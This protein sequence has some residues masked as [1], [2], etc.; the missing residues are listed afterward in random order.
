MKHK[1]HAKKP[2]KSFTAQ[3]EILG[4][5]AVVYRTI[6]N[7][8]YWQFRTWIKAEK[9]HFRISLKTR[10]LSTAVEKSK[11]LY[12]QLQSQSQ[13]GVKIFGISWREL[14]DDY[15]KEQ[16]VRVTTKRITVGRLGTI[17]SQLK[18]LLEFLGDDTKVGEIGRGKFI[19]YA[20]WRR[21]KNVGVR[22]VTIRNEHATINNLIKVA[23][24]RGYLPYA[25]AD[26]EEIRIR[27]DEIGRRDTFTAD[28]YATLYTSARTWVSEK[29]IDEEERRLR[30]MIR[31]FI[32]IAANSFARFGELRQLKWK[33]V[34]VFS[35]T[36]SKEKTTELVN[37]TIEG[38]TSKIRKSRKIVCNG[39]EYFQRL[40]SLSQHTNDEDY[41]FSNAR[42]GMIDKKVY[43]AL[44]HDL[45]TK[46]G[47]GNSKVSYYGLRHFGI[48]M[49][50]YAGVSLTDISRLA[51]TSYQYIENHY[52]HVDSSKLVAA[53]TKR[54]R[55]D[56]NGLIIR[57]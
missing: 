19:E 54:F 2:S 30:Q 16:E 3:H 17:K 40:R 25:S 12:L 42:G 4:G 8:D 50:I 41:V 11:T 10:D 43:Y 28:E 32:L 6:Q 31:H 34:N 13:N 53:A 23:N 24:R 15:L 55:M 51:G 26:L 37:L 21:L 38:E 36:D 48:T 44:W 20:Q 35:H 27:G 47:L 29:S 49:R 5:E 45:L 14:V 33:N 39:G 56:K 57:E 7:G 46:A 1:L 18:H 22:D 52:S 9:K